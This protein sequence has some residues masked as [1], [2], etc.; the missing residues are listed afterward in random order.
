MEVIKRNI[1][2]IIYGSLDGI[3]TTF[4]IIAGV[5]GA[6][7][8]IKIAFILAL[9]NL[10]ADGFSMGVSSY[11]SILQNEYP[12]HNL[13]RGIFTFL[14]FITIGFIPLSFFIWIIARN[15]PN[16]TFKK[17]YIKSIILL[18]LVAIILIGILKAHFKEPLIPGHSQRSQ[19]EKNKIKV[20]IVLRTLL[21]CVIAGIISYLVAHNLT[22]FLEKS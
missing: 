11:E 14:A 20:K 16:L 12:N 15:P 17:E 6:K 10:L 4:A 13:Y 7:Q 19:T 8:N 9:A 3:I 21:T 1:P 22:V 18:T 5:L 2:N